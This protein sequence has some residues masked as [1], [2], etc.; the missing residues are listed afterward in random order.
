MLIAAVFV[1]SPPLLVPELIGLAASETDDLRHAA[2]DGARRIGDVDEWIV[3]GTGAEAADVPS[4]AVGTFRGFGADVRVSLGPAAVTTPGTPDADMPLAALVAGWLRERAAPG[5]RAEVHVLARDTDPA[6][7]AQ[8]GKTL[9]THLDADT[10]RR[11]LLIVAD[12]A[13]T[14]TAKAPGALD[15]RSA[16]V[17]ESLRAA[18]A[19]GDPHGLA[20]FDAGLCEEIALAGRAA[21]QVLAGAFTQPPSEATIEYS[22]A[23]YG[24]GYHVGIWR[25]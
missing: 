4:H 15:E 12:G 3:V 21:W 9:R 5:A 2:L 24:V 6:D 14:L 18:L 16:A 1:P 7:C 23:P 13:A 8:L 17:E 25:P 20:A 10:T 22:A 19:A 11:G